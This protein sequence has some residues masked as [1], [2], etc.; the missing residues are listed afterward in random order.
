MNLAQDIDK[1]QAL[2]NVVNE[3]FGFIKGCEFLD[4]L[5]DQQLLQIDSAPNS[6]LDSTQTNDLKFTDVTEQNGNMDSVGSR[7]FLMVRLRRGLL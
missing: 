3:P 4:Q 7:D 5:S 6:Q 2:V 1:R